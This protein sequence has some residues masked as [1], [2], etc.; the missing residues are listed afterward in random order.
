MAE[1]EDEPNG[2]GVAEDSGNNWDG[3]GYE[4]S[5][6]ESKGLCHLDEVFAAG[7]GGVRGLGPRESLSRC[8]R[9]FRE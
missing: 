5:N 8:K 7:G 6:D 4:C 3:E 1:R 2:G 9:A